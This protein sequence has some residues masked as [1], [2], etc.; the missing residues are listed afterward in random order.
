MTSFRNSRI[1][2]L[3]IHEYRSAV[4]SRVLALLILSMV[5]ITAG[6]IVIAAYAFKVT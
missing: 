2:T 5:L 1:V 3:A 4:R 6:S